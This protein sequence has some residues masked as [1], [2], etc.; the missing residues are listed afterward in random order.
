M[1][2]CRHCLSLIFSDDVLWI[3]VVVVVIVTDAA[4]FPQNNGAS[5]HVAVRVGIPQLYSAK[6]LGEVWAGELSAGHIQAC[7]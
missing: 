4:S 7:M 5:D 3:F 6:W 2:S 1:I